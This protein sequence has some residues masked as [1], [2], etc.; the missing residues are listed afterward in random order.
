MK[1]WEGV[2]F[3]PNAHAER[4]SAITEEQKGISLQLFWSWIWDTTPK[5]T[6][7][8]RRSGESG[9][10]ID[11]RPRRRFQ[12]SASKAS[13]TSFPRFVPPNVRRPTSD[14][15]ICR[16]KDPAN[17]ACFAREE[18]AG[19]KLGLPPCDGL[20]TLW[21]S[22]AGWANAFVSSR[23]SGGDR[24]DRMPD[25]TGQNGILLEDGPSLDTRGDPFL[26]RPWKER[27]VLT[28]THGAFNAP[29]C[30]ATG[31]RRHRRTNG[32]PYDEVLW[33]EL[34]RK[35]LRSLDGAT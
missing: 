19:D 23:G 31:Q 14:V 26:R 10:S 28:F 35:A 30:A 20:R 6:R 11:L 5:P 32:P 1:T 8:S 3:I 17:E 13:S 25:Q 34:F 12:R 24:L 15:P 2:G 27:A 29:R 9:F 7:Q 16:C 33:M 22:Q 21:R 18:I 4:G